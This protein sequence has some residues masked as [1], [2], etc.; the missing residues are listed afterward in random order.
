MLAFNQTIV[1]KPA[2]LSRPASCFINCF[3]SSHNRPYIV[4]FFFVISATAHITL[5][6]SFLLHNFLACD[7]ITELL[8][9]SKKPAKKD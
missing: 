1:H 3:F 4:S 8:S 5:E 9:G 2:S 7:F 6:D